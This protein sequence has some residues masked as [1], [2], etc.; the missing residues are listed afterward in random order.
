MC[1]SIGPL[2][3]IQLYN[4]AWVPILKSKPCEIGM[5]FK[6]ASPEAYDIVIPLYDSICTTKK[7]DF[8]GND[9]Y[10]ELQCD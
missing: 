10:Y 6:K 3:W 5:T 1:L 8:F 4:K 7:K 2:H 9:D